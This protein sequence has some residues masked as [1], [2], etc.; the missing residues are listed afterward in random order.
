[1]TYKIIGFKMIVMVNWAHY[2]IVVVA[3]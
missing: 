3:F 2:L 1:M